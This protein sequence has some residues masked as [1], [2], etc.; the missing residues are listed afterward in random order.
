[1]N[2]I[3]SQV[4][5]IFRRPNVFFNSLNSEL[6]QWRGIRVKVQYGNLDQALTL[7]QRKMQSSGI[8]RIIKAHEFRHIKNS[9][10][11]VLARKKQEYKFR[12]QDLAHKLKA[13]L[14]KKVRGLWGLLW[15]V[16]F[17]CHYQDGF[18]MSFLLL[19]FNFKMPI[20][21][22]WPVRN[23]QTSSIRS[24]CIILHNSLRG[25]WV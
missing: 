4:S 6:Q 23:V 14:V 24:P 16:P 8:E 12:S 18:E 3:A 10:K 22:S 15:R 7:L 13:I 20:N 19:D 25:W 9:E 5:S 11:R 17:P 2:S 21:L 1:M